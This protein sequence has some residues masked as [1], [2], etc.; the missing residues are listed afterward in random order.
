[1]RIDVFFW[2]SGLTPGDTAGRVVVVVDVLRASTSIATALANG[3]RAVI[4]L[5]STDEVVMRAQAFDRSEVKLAGERQMRPIPGFDL[6]NSP[7][8]FT[9]ET[10]EGKTV[11]LSTTNGTGAITAL[12]GP[13]DVVIGSYVNFSAVLAMLRT[14]MRG[15]TDIAILCAGR[16]KQFS[17]EDAACAG[18][19]VHHAMRRRADVALNDAAFAGML[20]DRRYSDNLMRLF[21]ASA[22][23]RALSEAGYGDDLAACAAID[24]YPVIP[25][26]SD[27][28][29]TKLGPER[30]R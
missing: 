28:Q 29:I 17:L 12:Q 7:L 21:S 1:M 23:G 27:R 26:Y 6:G 2:T 24:S 25:I 19:F 5:D 30:A 15:G 14:A 11:L 8:E 10:I 4:P 20:I 18:R 13:R 16:E 9:R 22:H 3:A